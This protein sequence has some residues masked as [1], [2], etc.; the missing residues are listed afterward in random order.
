MFLSSY[1]MVFAGIVENIFYL[2]TDAA[3]GTPKKKSLRQQHGYFCRLSKF[4]FKPKCT[5]F[6]YLR[7]NTVT[8][9]V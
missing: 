1:I 8:A 3:V 2:R 6:P 9:S 4:E 7:N 5:P